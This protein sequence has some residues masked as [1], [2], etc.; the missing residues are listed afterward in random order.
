[1]NLAYR[2][3]LRGLAYVSKTAN[4][5]GIICEVLPLYSQFDKT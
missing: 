1:M 2:D 3:G 4:F 5:V